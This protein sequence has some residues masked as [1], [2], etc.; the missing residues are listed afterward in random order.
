[1]QGCVPSAA[2]EEGGEGGIDEGRVRLAG[3]MHEIREGRRREGLRAA[4]CQRGEKGGGRGCTRQHAREG[5]RE[6]GGAARGCMPER[7]EGK[8]GGSSGGTSYRAPVDDPLILSTTRNMLLPLSVQ[9]VAHL[10]SAHSALPRTLTSSP[11][12]FL[13]NWPFPAFPLLVRRERDFF[14]PPP[15]PQQLALSRVPATSAQ[16][17]RLFPPPLPEQ[18]APSRVPAACAQ[19]ARRAAASRSSCPSWR[20]CSAKRC[21]SRLARARGTAS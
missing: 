16:R 8:L 17:A 3:S 20:R 11:P 15:F 10:P 9:S 13:N 14:L 2:H 21:A 12:P 6:E 7:G 1:M 18:V 19:R 4:A 5:R